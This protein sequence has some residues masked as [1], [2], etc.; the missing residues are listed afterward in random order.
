MKSRD[1]YPLVLIE[2]AN[3]GADELF[4][5]S[6]YASASMAYR[7]LPDLPIHVRLHL[8]VGMCPQDG[9]SIS[10]HLSFRRLCMDDYLGRFECM[11]LFKPPPTHAKTYTWSKA[12]EPVRAFTGSANYSQ[13]AFFGRTVETVTEDDP[14][15]TKQFFEQVKS[16]AIHCTDGDVEKEIK[17]YT[18]TPVP[19]AP[20]ETKPGSAITITSLMPSVTLSFLDNNGYLPG[21]S[22]LNW[23]QRPEYRRDPNQAYIRVPVK[24]A[25]AMF[26]PPRGTHFTVFTDDGAAIDCV[27]AQAGEK[28]IES[29]PSNAI[30]GAY[31]RNRIGITSARAI[32]LSDLKKYGRTDVTFYKIGDESYYMDF[33]IP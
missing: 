15:E 24:V 20:I 19:K 1:L 21:R 18:G 2:P 6:G 26:F 5:V 28:A 8:I 25:R 32:T 4:I 22:G 9:M 3:Q 13:G 23:G 11:Y 12:G 17:F 31:F 10:N 7:H 30:I 16:G 14:T 29:K 33:S 27:V